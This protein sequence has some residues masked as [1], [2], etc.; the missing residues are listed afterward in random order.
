[1]FITVLAG[2]AGADSISLFGSSKEKIAE[3]PKDSAEKIY[4]DANDLLDQRKFEDAAKKFEEVDRLYP[5]S[6]YARRSVILAAVAYQK[7]G[8]HIEAIKA[9]KNYRN[10]HPGTKEASM[11]QNIIAQSY[12]EQISDENHDQSM[13]R[14][15]LKEFNTLL[16]RFPNSSYTKDA[17]NKI[18]IIADVLAASEMKVGHYYRKRG[19]YLA[20]VNRFKAVVTN[21]QRTRMV[22]EALMRLTETYLA[23]GVVNEAQTAAAVLGHNF[24]ESA[25]YRDAYAL[26][27]KRGLNPQEDKGSWISRVWP[28]KVQSTRS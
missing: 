26:L 7:G 5:Y 20:A 25:W 4:K 28:I 10:L 17:E 6:P 19:N 14:I 9:A 2:C 12:Y 8:S 13:S 1:M 24:P 3:A 27:Q 23:L 16:K 15:A 11:A 18:R 22:E 21:Y